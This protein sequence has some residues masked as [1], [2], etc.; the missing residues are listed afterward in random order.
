MQRF[1]GPPFF[2][3]EDSIDS[4]NM[5]GNCL[6]TVVFYSRTIFLFGLH[7]SQTDFDHV[8]MISDPQPELRVSLKKTWWSWKSAL[9]ASTGIAS[10]SI[11]WYIYHLISEDSP[12][13]PL[14]QRLCFMF[15]K[16]Y[17][18]NQNKKR[19]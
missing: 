9:S 16:I 18:K 2:R 4:V 3:R 14:C 10:S 17:M 11:P 6:V 19:K 5:S 7:V 12:P 1:N 15:P 8:V 13:L